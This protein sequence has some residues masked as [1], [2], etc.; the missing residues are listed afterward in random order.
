VRQGRECPD[1]LPEQQVE[2][3]GAGGHRV[4]GRA[5]LPSARTTRTVAMARPAVCGNLCPPPTRFP[6]NRWCITQHDQE[7]GL[8][9]R[10][11]VSAT[12]FAQIEEERERLMGR[13]ELVP[14]YVLGFHEHGPAA[15]DMR[16]NLTVA[17]GSFAKTVAPGT[18][19][20]SELVPRMPVT[21]VEGDRPI[22]A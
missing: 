1:R 15:H 2:C 11:E 21:V 4:L 9:V 12:T 8:L 20:F 13:S 5:G 14:I 6:V 17:T 19:V 16:L 7:A 10:H 18:T 22:R 3:R